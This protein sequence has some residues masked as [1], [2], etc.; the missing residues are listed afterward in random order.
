MSPVGWLQ[1]RVIEADWMEEW[2]RAVGV[3]GGAETVYY[4][5][6]NFI[7]RLLINIVI[8]VIYYTGSQKTDI[9]LL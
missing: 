9:S 2:L 3:E 7:W 1:V 8:C 6:N 5:H 4:Y